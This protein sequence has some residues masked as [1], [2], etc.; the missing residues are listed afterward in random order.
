MKIL[1]L[2]ISIGIILFLIL[3]LILVKALL[4]IDDGE[5]KENMIL[6]DYNKMTISELKKLHDVVGTAFIIENGHISGVDF[7]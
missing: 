1:V 6:T 5:E 3:F 7:N 4:V 2:K